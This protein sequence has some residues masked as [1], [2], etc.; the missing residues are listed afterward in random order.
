MPAIAPVGRSY[1]WYRRSPGRQAQPH[2]FADKVRSCESS[3]TARSVGPGH[4]I[5]TAHG[6]AAHN[7]ERLYALCL[8]CL[9]NLQHRLHIHRV[10]LLRPQEAFAVLQVHPLDQEHPEQV[11]IDVL[12]AGHEGQDLQ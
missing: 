5:D 7:R 6:V 1:K 10:D 9:Q 11:R 12:V 3:P 4:G 8:D 2:R